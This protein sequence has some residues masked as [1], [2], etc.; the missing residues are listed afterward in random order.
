MKR[1]A[2]VVLAIVSLC[3][4]N[5]VAQVV[6]VQPGYGTLNAAIAANGG[7]KTYLLQAGGWYGLDATLEINA[8]L[9]IQGAT[10][11]PGQMKAMIQTGTN[12]DGTTFGVMFTVNA[13]ITFRNVFLVNADLNNG[14]GAIICNQLQPGRVEMDSVT[15]DPVGSMIFLNLIT[16]PGNLHV[17]NSLIMRHANSSNGMF[18][19]PFINEVSTAGFDTIYVENTTFVDP[20]F[21]FYNAMVSFQRG[22]A[23]FDKFIWFNHN[24]FFF[25][26]SDLLNAFYTNSTFFTNNLMWEWNIVPF[27]NDFGVWFK[28]FGDQGP[29]NTRTCLVK[30]D[31]LMTSGVPEAFP[32]SREYFV[33]YNY[34]YRD[35]RINDLIH[36]GLDSGRVSY[37]QYLVT[38]ASMKDSS[39]EAGMFSDKTNFPK[40][41]AAKNT[42]DQPG[43]NPNFA[44]TK[45][46]AL[47]DSAIAWANCAAKSIWGFPAG[48]FP[49]A[50]EWPRYYYRADTADGNP[51]AWPRF[52][53]AYTNSQLMTGSIEGLPLGDLNWFPTQKAVWQTRQASVMA[54]ILSLDTTVFTAVQ[55]FDNLLPGKYVLSQNYPNPFNPSTQI[56]YSMPRSGLVTLKVFN[57]LGQEVALLVNQQQS[58]GNYTVDFNAKGLASGVY[59][60]RLQAENIALSKSMVLVK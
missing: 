30:A 43:T 13:S 50:A 40:F 37:L 24:S 15:I 8:P 36:L 49:P 52:N 60:Y 45:I 44:D 54:H 39:R 28:N 17:T 46:Y 14:W 7:D 22:G 11:A 20:G 1:I 23:A 48:T 29:A 27:N 16:G 9:T 56:R 47:T 31:T 53:G 34:N 25:G 42:E 21:S 57:L 32:S 51:I 35:P 58:A 59:V 2:V 10:P 5:L 3:S 6:Q 41:I 33:A 4:V 38:P 26:K 55:E 18:D 12:P 19:Y